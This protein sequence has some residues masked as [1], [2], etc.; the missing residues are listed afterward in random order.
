MY[1]NSAAGADRSIESTWDNW[2]TEYA[3]MLQGTGSEV[4]GEKID[5]DC[6]R[7]KNAIRHLTKENEQLHFDAS[8]VMK[9]FSVCTHRR[10]PLTAYQ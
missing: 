1:T 4:E 7:K 3:R 10:T 2:G 6:L 8:K 9:S 5:V